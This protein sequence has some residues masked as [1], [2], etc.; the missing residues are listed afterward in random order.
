MNRAAGRLLFALAALTVA[1]PAFAWGPQA[2][3]VITIVANER[4]TPAARAGVKELLNEG[5]TLVDVASWADNAGY[6]VFPGS[7]SWHYVNV[8]ISARNYEER[9]CARGDCVVEKIKHFRKVLANRNS[10][11]RERQHA[12]LFLVHF[13][14]DIHQPLHVGDNRD[15]G[16]NQTQIQFLDR[17][18]NLHRLWD[19]DLIR[20]LGG[21]DRTWTERVRLMITPETVK[22]WSQGTVEDW[23]TESLRAAKRAYSGPGDMS[24]PLASG[25]RLGEDYVK[26]A[27][28][29]LR[30]QMG[31]ASVRLANELNA[32]FR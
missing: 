4:L 28:P 14:G 1:S 26:M 22:A 8:P 19:S 30:E 3:R 29:I 25:A 24:P 21:N 6:D 11:R 10:P 12:L 31:R 13:V 15:R 5:D 23:A 7:A 17:G 27:D 16:G 2:H 18:T 20:H 9:Y 32:I